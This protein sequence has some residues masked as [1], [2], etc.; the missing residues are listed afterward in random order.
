MKDGVKPHGN[1]T[2]PRVSI[3]QEI[4]NSKAPYI[5]VCAPPCTGKTS[6]SILVS[7][8]IVDNT[9][10]PCCTFSFTTMPDNGGVVIVDEVQIS[11]NCSRQFWQKVKDISIKAETREVGQ[12]IMFAAYGTTS[13]MA[14]HLLSLLKSSIQTK[15]VSLQRNTQSFWTAICNTSTTLDQPSAVT[16]QK[17]CSKTENLLAYR[18]RLYQSHGVNHNCT[19]FNPKEPLPEDLVTECIMC[20]DPERLR[21]GLCQE[22]T[23]INTT[24]K[25]KIINEEQRSPLEAVW[26]QQFYKALCRVLSTKYEVSP[27]YGRLWGIQGRLDFYVNG[28]LKYGFELLRD[29]RRIDEHI[30]RFNERY[31]PLVAPSGPIK[32]AVVVDFRPNCLFKPVRTTLNDRVDLDVTQNTSWKFWKVG[33]FIHYVCSLNKPHRHATE[34]EISAPCGFNAL[35][36]YDPLKWTPRHIIEEEEEYQNMKIDQDAMV[37]IE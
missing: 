1:T 34:T 10:R 4:I 36:S 23:A 7:Q 19:I 18:R 37:D 6:L 20:M 12:F 3:V 16:F 11:Y 33:L 22:G 21:H 29:G 35:H 17:I 31:A 13:A 25:R 24:T 28:E 30:E 15:F 5:L 27:E 2:V 14:L 26:Q 8:Y 9:D 32:T